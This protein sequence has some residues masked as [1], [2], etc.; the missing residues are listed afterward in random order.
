M[1]PRLH[2]TKQLKKT[3]LYKFL[4]LDF[5]WT[6]MLRTIS[7]LMLM[8]MLMLSHCY[9]TTHLQEVSIV[10]TGLPQRL[11]H[12]FVSGRLITYPISQDFIVVST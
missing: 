12:F 11:A 3:K 2:G 1:F 6:V 7:L 4:H 9:Y 8:L 5:T 10:E